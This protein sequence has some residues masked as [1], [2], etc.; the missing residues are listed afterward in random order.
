MH[1]PPPPDIFPHLSDFR[2]KRLYCDVCLKFHQSPLRPK[3]YAH[4]IV[5]AS[6]SSFFADLCQDD[7]TTNKGI[8]EISI[9]PS[10]DDETINF[11]IR[12]MYNEAPKLE[13][14][15]EE[16][17][18]EESWQFRQKLRQAAIILGIR[19]LLDHLDSPEK[20][21]D[22]QDRAIDASNEEYEPDIADQN[23]ETEYMIE[24]TRT[25]HITNLRANGN[26]KTYDKGPNLGIAVNADCI[27]ID[28]E[29]NDEDLTND[30][31]KNLP[32]SF[33]IDLDVCPVKSELNEIIGSHSSYDGNTKFSQS[34]EAD[35]EMLQDSDHADERS[36]KISRS[37]DEGMRFSEES[38]LREEGACSEK[39][40]SFKCNTCTEPSR[41]KDTISMSVNCDECG[42]E[43]RR[44][45]LKL[46]KNLKHSLSGKVTCNE[47]G[48][49]M[50]SYNLKRHKCTQHGKTVTIS[51][52][53]NCD[54]CGKEVS[55][56]SLSAHEKFKH[57][58]S[59]KGVACD[60]CGKVMNA[61][62]LKHH[63]RTQHGSAKYIYP[64]KPC[65][66]C[67]KI[68]SNTAT[69]THKRRCHGTRTKVTC[70]ECGKSF[71]EQNL[72]SHKKMVHGN[73]VVCDEC[74]QQVKR[75]YL[76]THKEL[77]HGSEKRCE[78]CKKDFSSLKE[79]KKHRPEHPQMFACQTCNYKTK[80]K[81]HYMHHNFVKHDVIVP[82][83]EEIHKCD[84]CDFKSPA[85]KTV[86]YH[87]QLKHAPA[88]IQCLDPNC[89]KLFSN[90]AYRQRHYNRIHKAKEAANC[91][92]CQRGMLGST[93]TQ[94]KPS[95]RFFP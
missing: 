12:W 44:S 53:V 26:L 9:P 88:P 24:R 83:V 49:Q 51:K 16:E 87:I 43:V 85:R 59:E 80:D 5:L 39:T 55:R 41:K 28:V 67:G 62:S 54:E 20:G 2:L 25:E 79:L 66:E 56:P 6:F 17:G 35:A 60:H 73:T 76:K 90:T 92:E 58:I 37:A 71:L 22:N 93:G 4:R 86:G 74:G 46:H 52:R 84:K 15:V 64:K 61:S 40:A 63:K 65:D 47:C 3:I 27:K 1:L 7:I 94:S 31:K 45:Y 42:K 34:V 48:K 75:H 14:K 68:I 82:E 32:T 89:D 10:I 50:K 95:L 13:P 69:T 33:G 18:G 8:K 19:H 11:V 29:D 77:I 21:S 36:G 57:S 78:I 23:V 30:N 91:P 38:L 81:Q 70:E 72:K